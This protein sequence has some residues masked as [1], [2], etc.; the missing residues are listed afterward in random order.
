MEMQDVK[1][2]LPEVKLVI[3]ETVMT[4]LEPCTVKVDSAKKIKSAIKGKIP[5]DHIFW[6]MKRKIIN[7]L[8]DGVDIE[9]GDGTVIALAMNHQHGWQ[10]DIPISTSML[11]KAVGQHVPVTYAAFVHNGLYK[12]K[13][14]DA[15]H[16]SPKAKATLIELGYITNGD[17]VVTNAGQD[18]LDRLAKTD[19]S[20]DSSCRMKLTRA[21][22][23]RN[24]PTLPAFEWAKNNDFIAYVSNDTEPR[25]PWYVYDDPLSNT[26]SRGATWYPTMRGAEWLEKN[27]ARILRHHSCSKTRKVEMI[28]FM[29]LDH[30]SE[31]LS[32]Q[33]K[34]IRG[35]ADRRLKIVQPSKRR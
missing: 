30:L 31:Y 7:V 1:I 11:N 6:D 9:L 24:D 2:K 21:M 29:P 18:V 12:L 27:A 13:H 25:Q 20:T 3:G 32:H 22:F 19:P 10:F 17:Y 35:L 15:F 4:V 28:P 14:G 26:S 34:D 5:K 8:K 23:C 16:V 33:D